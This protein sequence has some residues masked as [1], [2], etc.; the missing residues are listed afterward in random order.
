MYYPGVMSWY[1]GQA[2]VNGLM[3]GAGVAA[4]GAIFGGF[5]WNNRDVNINVNHFNRISRNNFYSGQGNSNWKHNPQH[6]GAVAYRDNGSRQKYSTRDASA[7][8]ARNELRGHGPAQGGGA[9]AGDRAPVR[10]AANAGQT[11]ARNAVNANHAPA[12]PAAAAPA[13]NLE[14]NRPAPQ[15][16]VVQQ[17]AAQ[18]QPAARADAFKGVDAGRQSIDRGRASAAAASRPN[19]GQGGGRPGGGGGGGRMHGRG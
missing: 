1:P 19:V 12:R 7:V 17:R 9:L 14:Q 10:N 2:V 16:E 6:R 11:P 3:W 5:N 13:R 18:A 8:N 4:A 15:R